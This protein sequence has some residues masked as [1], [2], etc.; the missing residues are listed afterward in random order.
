MMITRTVQDL[1]HSLP[2]SVT[3][4][5]RDSVTLS[6]HTARGVEVTWCGA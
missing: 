4:D 2:L 1:V 6:L 3:E 5:I